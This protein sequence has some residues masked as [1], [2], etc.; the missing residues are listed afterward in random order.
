MMTLT[1]GRKSLESTEKIINQRTL[2]GNKK[3]SLSKIKK[4]AT[5]ALSTQS[6]LETIM[7]LIS[8]PAEIYV[9]KL[10]KITSETN[11]CLYTRR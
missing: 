8:W 10:P 6:P 7:K 9:R 1:S 3:K 5:I 4:L 11:L 2:D